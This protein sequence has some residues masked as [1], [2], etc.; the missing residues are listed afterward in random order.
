MCEAPLP[1]YSSSS[2]TTENYQEVMPCIIPFFHIYGLTY[3]LMSKL[4]LGFK[5]VTL[6]RFE[7]S[8]YLNAI[9]EHKATFLTVVPPI[10]HFLNNDN[11]CQ[12][13]HFK[14]VQTLVYAAAPIGSEAV[15]SFRN[16][17]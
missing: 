14:Y 1:H 12:K 11:R 2:P 10:F 9:A 7:P 3:L 4:S 13:E 8:S 15:E 5:L 6:P 17:K 16:T